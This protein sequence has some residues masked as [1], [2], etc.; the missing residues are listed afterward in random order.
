MNPQR[1]H[2]V[3]IDREREPLYPVT[4]ELSCIKHAGRLIYK[5]GKK[6]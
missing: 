5:T 4:E 2:Y 3:H 1:T 6:Q